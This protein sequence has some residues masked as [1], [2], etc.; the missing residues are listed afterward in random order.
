MKFIA[1]VIGAK[2]ADIL[3]SV[4]SEPERKGNRENI[5]ERTE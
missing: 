3:I 1:L 5:E 2:F 4:P